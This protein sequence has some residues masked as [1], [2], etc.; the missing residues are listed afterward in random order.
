MVSE[1]VLYVT[2]IIP[3]EQHTK[4][5]CQLLLQRAPAGFPSPGDDYVDKAL[6]LNELVIKHPAATFF[7]RV[8]GESM[9][10]A[11]IFDGDM[12]VVDR[13]VE[14]LN[15]DIVVVVLDGELVVKKLEITNDSRI[16][17]VA[18]NSS[19]APIEITPDMKFEIW[20]VVTY[21]LHPHK[22]KRIP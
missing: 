1:K 10:D 21:S 12:L 19:Y 14:A 13:A 15:N 11:G 18:S 22:F 8:Q 17:L 3:Y 2:E 16:R 5:E 6:D 7:L 4:I 9:K 20:G